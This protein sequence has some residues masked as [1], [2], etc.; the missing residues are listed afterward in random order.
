VFAAS[1]YR[2]CGNY[3]RV[4]CDKSVEIHATTS[5]SRLLRDTKR[6]DEARPML[7]IY[8]WF[9]EGFDTAYLK[10]AKALLDELSKDKN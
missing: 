9:T 4:A 3:Q 5:L 1:L 6:G 2:R 7:D 10:E 8:G